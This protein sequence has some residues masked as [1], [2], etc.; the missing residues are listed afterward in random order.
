VASDYGGVMAAVDTGEGVDYRIEVFASPD[1]DPSGT[2]EGSH[3]LG[4][5]QFTG[6]GAV[7]S[8][9]VDFDE[10]LPAP[11]DFLTATATNLSTGDTSR[12]SDCFS[13]Q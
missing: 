3:R 8:Y 13:V 9:E 6:D 1:C 5:A 2:G 11:G 7:D 4:A 10:G 12:F